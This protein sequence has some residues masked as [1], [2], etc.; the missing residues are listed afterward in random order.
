VTAIRNKR[1]III[2]FARGRCAT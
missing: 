1:I 2:F